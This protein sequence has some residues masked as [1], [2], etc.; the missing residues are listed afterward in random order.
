[1]DWEQEG[2]TIQP[3]GEPEAGRT[4]EEAPSDYEQPALILEEGSGEDEDDVPCEQVPFL[5]EDE[6]GD[7]SDE[8]AEDTASE[9]EDGTEG[10]DESDEEEV[11]GIMRGLH[12]HLQPNGAGDPG[13]D[14][15]D[16]ILNH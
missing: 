1:M 11:V 9:D 10:G 4:E 16:P 15:L 13:Y 6:E 2:S 5:E 8:A 3:S 14:P 12:G 7:D